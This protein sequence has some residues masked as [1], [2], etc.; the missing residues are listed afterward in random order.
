MLK[1]PRDFRRETPSG[2]FFKLAAPPSEEISIVGAQGQPGAGFGTL[3]EDVEQASLEQTALVMAGFR[4]GVGKEHKNTGQ[5]DIRRQSGQG[6]DDIGIKGGEVR[7]LQ[8]LLLALGAL[9][10]LFDEVDTQASNSRMRGGISGEKVPMAAANFK[11][12]GDGLR[13]KVGQCS[14][15][16]GLSGG[17]PLTDGEW[18]GS[19]LSGA[20]HGKEVFTANSRRTPRFLTKSG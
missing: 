9:D 1:R 16:G 14:D 3:G 5:L 2:V 10:A 4:P 15:E 20:G 8:P 13:V 18:S 11:D 6:L 17:I 12:D 19:G 7:E